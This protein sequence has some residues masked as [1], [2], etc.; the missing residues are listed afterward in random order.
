MKNK[1]IGFL[2]IPICIS[3]EHEPIELLSLQDFYG[4]EQS[5]DSNTKIAEQIEIIIDNRYINLI[6]KIKSLQNVKIKI[7]DFD[8]RN[9][10]QITQIHNYLNI[11]YSEENNQT[12][13]FVIGYK[14]IINFLEDFHE[15]FVSYINNFTMTKEINDV[16][17]RLELVFDIAIKSFLGSNQNIVGEFN[18]LK[19]KTLN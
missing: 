1:I 15:L 3:E 10:N 12:I 2:N 14:Y 16:N 11:K 19:N 7:I 8:I 17:N 6:D 18:V 5:I 4:L 9:Y 13:T